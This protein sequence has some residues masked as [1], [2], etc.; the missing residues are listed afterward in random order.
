MDIKVR[1]DRD[2]CVGLGN[3][4]A[5]AP[6]VFQLDK[7]NKAIILNSATVDEDTLRMAA[8]SCPEHAVILE[9]ETGNQL[10]P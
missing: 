9:D 10:Y 6:S 4:V 7:E 1:I 3:C 5:I 2:L 8:A